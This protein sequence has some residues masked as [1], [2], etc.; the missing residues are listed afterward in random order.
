MNE[1]AQN[2][3]EAMNIPVNT[4]KSL[5]NPHL[6]MKNCRCL[7]IWRKSFVMSGLSCLGTTTSSKSSDGDAVELRLNNARHEFLKHAM[8]EWCELEV[9][10]MTWMWPNADMWAYVG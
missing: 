9:T 10:W 8:L 3:Y 1:S 2:Q 5:I 4:D 6:P 7:P